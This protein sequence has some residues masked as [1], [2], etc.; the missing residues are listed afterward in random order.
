MACGLCVQ[1]GSWNPTKAPRQRLFAPFKLAVDIKGSKLRKL[2]HLYLA[3]VLKAIN[4][5][6]PSMVI[7]FG[8]SVTKP[9]C[10]RAR[11]FMRAKL[12]VEPL[13]MSANIEQ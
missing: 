10:Q 3:V 1:T 9:C 4:K 12:F 5:F 11:L 13:V 8:K 2:R 6:V 7:L